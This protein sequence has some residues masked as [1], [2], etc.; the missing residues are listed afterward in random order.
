MGAAADFSIT[1]MRWNAPR[2]CATCDVRH[3]SVCG[4]IPETAL[5][6]LGLTAVGGVARAGSLFIEEAD[7]AIDFFNITSGIARLFRSLPDGRRQITGFAN[8]GDFLGL[9]ASGT[10][11]CSVQAIDTVHYCRFPRIRLRALIHD[12]PLMEEHLLEAASRELVAAQEQM[13]L[14]G[15]KTAL[16][17]VASFLMAQSRFSVS[18]DGSEIRFVLPMA[19][20]DIADY[21]GL[22][23]ETVARALKKLCDEQMIEVTNISDVMIRDQFSLR[24]ITDG[25][26]WTQRSAD[27]PKPPPPTAPP[28]RA[29][30]PP[31]HPHRTAR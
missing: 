2:P 1:P 31:E 7:P 11:G 17:R 29:T 16:E 22:T 4:A 13:L 28:P 20:G 10:Y 14:L 21:L 18:R 15:R 24:Q 3:T 25:S 12:F 30:M 9:A 19:R 8:R 23:I 27:A 26:Y 6:R 5:D